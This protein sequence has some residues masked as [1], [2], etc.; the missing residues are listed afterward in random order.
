MILGDDEGLAFVVVGIVDT[1]AVDLRR[2]ILAGAEKRRIRDRAMYFF[3]HRNFQ[4][5]TRSP[6]S[7]PGGRRECDGDHGEGVLIAPEDRTTSR[8]QP[9]HQRDRGRAIAIAV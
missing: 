4:R 3:A 1:V 2:L 6:S 5:S 7:E 9:D 8:G